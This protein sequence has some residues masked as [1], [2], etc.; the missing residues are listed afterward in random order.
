MARDS[1]NSKNKKEVKKKGGLGRG[2]S[3]LFE[4]EPQ[5]KPAEEIEDLPLEEVRPNP[6]QPR[7]NFDEKKL[8]ELAES[9]KENGVLQPI[10]VRRSVGG[11]EIIAGE[12][13]FRASEL[14]GKTTIPAI[15]RHFGSMDRIGCLH[16]RNIKHLGADRRFRES[17]HLS[18]EGDLDMFEIM[19]AVYDTC[20]DTYVRP[21]HGR[22][23]WDEV[24]RPGYGLYDRALG[25]TYL[26]GLWEAI[27]KMSK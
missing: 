18:S 7:K 3:A 21:D 19:K 27:C 17:A 10:I 2:L 5:V 14:S 15:I 13:R 26:N 16:I 9:I 1:R 23:I 8:G 6:Y 4:E 11:Y 22:M 12:R 24:G 20:P 25:L